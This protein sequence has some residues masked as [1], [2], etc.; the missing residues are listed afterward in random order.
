MC[1]GLEDT[2]VDRSKNLTKKKREKGK[3]KTY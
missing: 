2:T 3:Q 1:V